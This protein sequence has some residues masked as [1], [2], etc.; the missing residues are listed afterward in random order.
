MSGVGSSLLNNGIFNFLSVNYLRTLKDTKINESW[1]GN[2]KSTNMGENQEWDITIYYQ[3]NNYYIRT[4]IP[5]SIP[6]PDLI[7]LVLSETN[8]KLNWANTLSYDKHNFLG[9]TYKSGKAN[10]VKYNYD[11]NNCFVTMKLINVKFVKNEQNNSLINY[12]KS[13]PDTYSLN[14]ISTL[15]PDNLYYDVT[16]YLNLI[17]QI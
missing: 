8:L 13:N 12:L 4:V 10:Y 17:K 3:N 7:P 14:E 2:W 6:D 9:N 1:L 15:D 5:G 16:I 11:D